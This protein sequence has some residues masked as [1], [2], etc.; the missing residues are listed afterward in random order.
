MS[1]TARFDFDCNLVR[2]VTCDAKSNN[3]DTAGFRTRGGT[4]LVRSGVQYNNIFSFKSLD[5]FYDQ[6]GKTR[7]A[8]GRAA[9]IA[10]SG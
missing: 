8:M 5:I 9:M 7:A 4:A 2:I 10:H 6:I 1:D 3:M